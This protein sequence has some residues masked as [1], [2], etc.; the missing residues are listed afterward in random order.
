MLQVT[1]GCSDNSN[2]HPDGAA[3]AY[4][5]ELLLLEDAEQL[6]LSFERQLTDF[7]QEDR[8]PVRQLEA[9]HTPVNS[10]RE[11]TLDVT[12]QLALDQPGGDGAAVHLHQ[13]PFLARAAVM[14][15]P[16]DQLLPGPGLA[17]DEHR[18]I[19]GRD[20]LHLA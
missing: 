9:A 5:L 16:R 7:V 17:Q 2:V 12:E 13:R 1:V 4:R 6:D 15:R 14:D 11:R 19:R 10:P 8:A 20:L 18:S 3:A